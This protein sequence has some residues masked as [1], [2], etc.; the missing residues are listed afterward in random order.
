MEGGAVFNQSTATI[1]KSTFTNNKA[2]V[3]GGGALLNAYGTTTVDGCTFV[4]NSG[5]GGGVLDNDTT[6][7][8]SN[9]TMVGNTG[10][11][12]GGGAVQNFGVVHLTTSTLSGN[13]SPYGANIY[14][15]G[16]STLTVSAS[17]VADGVS[18]SNCGGTAI[19]DG[20]YNLDTAT[21]CRFSTANHSRSSAKPMLQ[22]LASNGGPTQ[23][24]ALTPGSPAL[25]VIPASVAG[26]T[27]TTDQRGT[28][29]PQG[30]ACDIGAYELIVTSSDTQAPST[31]T[32]L[33][34]PSTVSGGVVISWNSSTDNVGVAGYTVYRNG[35]A[36]GVTGGSITSYRDTSAA[37][38]STY[39]YTVDAFDAAGNHSPQSA[40]LSV[41]T[42]APPPVTA[43]WVQGGAA[44]TG[45]T[46]TSLT[47]GLPSAVGA[48]DLLVGWFGQYDS[49]GQVSVSDNVNGAWTRAPVSTTFGSHGDIALYYVANAAPA[50]SGL[51]VTVSAGAATYLQASAA[52]Y[53][54]IATTSPLDQMSASRGSGTTVDSGATGS[55]A[56]GEL[57]FS[58]MMTGGAPGTATPG[59]GLVLHDHTSGYSVDDADMPVG[60]AG[61]QHG[62]WTLQNSTDWYAVSAVFHTSSGP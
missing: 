25:D 8:I 5:P 53:A 13:S 18:G 31:P 32:G 34:A 55:A 57:L 16:S 42:T 10:G 62:T 59:G 22:P 39:S 28:S 44:G 38:A 29:R 2:T 4:G 46:V 43:H 61:P 9:S 20:G 48:G 33:T 27:G 60:T 37:A 51:T 41:S 12:H 19:L 54:G 52:D 56:A 58:A 23:T 15:Y 1:T 40:P 21:S 45:S 3:Y 14:N 6:T 47:V 24:M 49:A 11:S 35:T 17:I 36:L 50:P 30:P 7:Y 26:C